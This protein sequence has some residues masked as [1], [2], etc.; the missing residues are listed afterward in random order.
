MVD[1]FL[2]RHPKYEIDDDIGQRLDGTDPL[3]SKVETDWLR[4]CARSECV[5]V[6]LRPRQLSRPTTKRI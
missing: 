3:W 6:E 5:D 2:L 4:V 1:E